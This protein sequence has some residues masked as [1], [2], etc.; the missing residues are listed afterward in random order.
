M[1]VL[2]QQP[3]VLPNFNRESVQ[4]SPT[5]QVGAT[6]HS[7]VAQSLAQMSHMQIEV[8]ASSQAAMEVANA[9]AGHPVTSGWEEIESHQ[10][11]P[12]YQT[13]RIQEN[14]RKAE[15]ASPQDPEGAQ[16]IPKNP[17]EY[18]MSEVMIKS[19]ARPN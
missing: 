7:Q 8:A 14:I 6:T 18:Q 19:E 9:S 4:F 13:S 10:T 3:G 15:A 11:G 1:Y 2:P 17:E 5:D 12:I 16:E